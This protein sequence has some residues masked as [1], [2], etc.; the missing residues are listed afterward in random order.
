MA[1][2]VLYCTAKPEHK[3][4]DVYVRTAKKREH[5][6]FLNVNENN[7]ELKL[8]RNKSTLCKG[9]CLRLHANTTLAMRKQETSSIGK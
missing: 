9:P 7:S 8:S 2:N 5:G 1:L 3:H 6:T 4:G